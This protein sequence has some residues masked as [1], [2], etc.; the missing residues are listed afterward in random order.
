LQTNASP[1]ARLDA[2]FGTAGL[3]AWA[4][5]YDHF[6]DALTARTCHG[7]PLPCDAAGT[8]VSEA[9]AASVFAIGDFEYDYIWHAAQ[10]A[11]DY[12]S[13]TFGAFFA[14][15]A[16]ALEEP[17]HRLALYVGHDGSLVRLLAGLGAVP[18]RWPSFGSEVVFEIWEVSGMRYVRVFHEGTLLSGMEWV[19]LDEFFQKLRGLVP[20]QLFEQCMGG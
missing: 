12:T 20:N 17:T 7:H 9:D 3:D 14:E 10:N 13:L 19:G 11:S 4:N 8:C 15:L 2:V 18:L 1:K 6:F 5:W 16:D